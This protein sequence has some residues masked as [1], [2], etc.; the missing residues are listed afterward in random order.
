MDWTALYTTLPYMVSVVFH[1]T[2]SLDIETL[3]DTLRISLHLIHTLPLLL[4]KSGPASLQDS[5][6]V[7]PVSTVTQLCF[8]TFTCISRLFINDRFLRGGT[9]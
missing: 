8:L 4:W 6:S 1:Q 5:G 2:Q 9:R 3:E 7:L